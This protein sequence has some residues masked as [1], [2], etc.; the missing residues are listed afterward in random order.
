MNPQIKEIYDLFSREVC[1][2]FLSEIKELELILGRPYL[3][4]EELEGYLT[5]RKYKELQEYVF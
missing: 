1:E 3:L 4:R 5:E 2:A